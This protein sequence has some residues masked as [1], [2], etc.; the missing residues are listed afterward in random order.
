M[1]LDR[2]RVEVGMG[3]RELTAPGK[4]ND[5]SAV[6]GGIERQDEV[7][8]G[9]ARA[10]E[11]RVAAVLGNLGHCRPGGRAPRIADESSSGAAEGSEAF[12]LLVTDR[13]DQGVRFEPIAGIQSDAP[14][15]I[16]SA[17][18][19]DGRRGDVNS[20][21]LGLFEYL[22]EIAPEPAARNEVAPASAFRLDQPRKMVGIVGPCAHSL[23]ADV[24]QMRRLRG[25][26]G[27]TFSDSPAAVNED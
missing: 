8:H 11:H 20:G 24:Q 13:Q 5:P 23:G 16:S 18:L 26:V 15:I 4:R 12:G 1:F 10:D 19:R 17:R 7:D 21:P 2:R 14:A 6:S 9:K 3:T 27:N 25:R 22:A